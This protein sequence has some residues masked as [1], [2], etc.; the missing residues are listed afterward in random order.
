MLASAVFTG[1]VGLYLWRRRETAG[2]LPLSLAAMVIAAWCLANAA[3]ISATD[4]ETQRAWFIL[5]DAL[6]MP[7]VVAAVWFA[8]AY[9]GFSRWL[10][11]PVVALLVASIIAH[12]PFYVI[13][14]GRLLWSRIWWD[15]GVRADLAPLG[16]LFSAYGFGLF[17]VATAIFVLLF[18]RSPAHRLPVALILAGQLSIRAAYPLESLNIL[19]VPNLPLV[20]LAFDFAALMY[21]IALV[22]FRIFDLVPIAR[23]TI[24]ERMPDAMLVIDT[25]DRIVDLNEAAARLLR[26]DRSSVLRKP[27]AVVLASLPAVAA[28]VAAPVTRQGEI[29]LTGEPDGR[30]LQVSDTEFT[31]WQGR[32]IGRLV[33]LHDITELR[34]TQERL[35]KREKALAVARERDHMARE[36]HDSVGQVLGYVSMEADAM[37]AL[38]ADGRHAETRDQ[39]ARLADVARN[40]HADVRGYIHELRDATVAGEPLVAS[41]RREIEAFGRNYGV[42][43]RLEVDP[44][45]ERFTLVHEAQ[46]QVV[47]IVQEAL[48]N[49]RR[50]GFATEVRVA[51][52]FEDSRALVVIE[53]D[54]IGFDV[55]AIQPDEDGRFGLRFMRE[56]AAEL[57]GELEVRSVPDEGTRVVVRVPILSPEM[58]SIPP[59][60]IVV[61][62]GSGGRAR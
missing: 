28:W 34:L 55:S 60:A 27:A 25:R 52:V 44:A 10:T 56:R 1:A 42:V 36:L 53:D 38:L 35:V 43:T 49:A 41:L 51:L 16:A 15:G 24:I 4:F 7:G 20:V 22:R 33:V 21:V 2:A 32:V 45:L 59:E 12:L 40:A 9:A 62:A 17:L 19:N 14:D 29:T 47:R 37:R 48:S 50:H 13:D 3:E 30:L 39:L 54:G 8:L 58:A 57:G 61:G 31:D 11:R 6:A 46:T 23:E 18:V 5:R 26:A